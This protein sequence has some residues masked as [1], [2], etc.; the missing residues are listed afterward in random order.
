MPKVRTTY[1]LLYAF[2]VTFFFSMSYIVYDNYTDQKSIYAGQ[3]SENQFLQAKQVARSV[4]D[5]IDN[6]KR[7]IEIFSTSSA[8]KTDDKKDI[9][10]EL[11]SFY[12][13]KRDDISTI[14]IY[15]SSGRLSFALPSKHYRYKMQK[16]FSEKPFFKDVSDSKKTSVSGVTVDEIAERV[17]SISAPIMKREGSVSSEDFLG[18]ISVTVRLNKFESLI[19]SSVEAE[20]DGFIW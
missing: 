6:T 9:I 3:Y 15:D 8:L 4:Q 12:R 10:R 18:V 2:F 20:F 7:E 16:S 1:Y 14:R 5:A 11:L 17:I 13:L 19:N